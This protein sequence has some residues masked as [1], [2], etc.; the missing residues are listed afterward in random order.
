MHIK[1]ESASKR[2]VTW[3]SRFVVN[4][5][6]G[7]N[8]GEN[9]ELKKDTRQP[10]P[11]LICVLF[12]HCFVCTACEVCSR[13]LYCFLFFSI[14][15]HTFASLKFTFL[16]IR[17]VGAYFERV[18]A[19]FFGYLTRRKFQIVQLQRSLMTF[20]FLP[21]TKNSVRIPRAN[22]PMKISAASSCTSQ[23]VV[24]V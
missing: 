13:S 6:S 18:V 12:F 2:N 1:K 3:Q 11:L 19:T 15:L 9:E 17:T 4:N 14:S 7:R 24:F 16:M 10:L 5:F 23:S 20:F 21:K 22:Y 8:I